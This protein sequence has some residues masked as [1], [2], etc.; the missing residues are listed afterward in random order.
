M[1]EIQLR[2]ALRQAMTEEMDRDPNV[3]L[4]GEEVATLVNEIKPPGRYSVTWDGSGYPSGVYFYR[5]TG[6]EYVDTKKMVLMK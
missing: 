6:G 2:E 3:F 5:L 4:L 1:P